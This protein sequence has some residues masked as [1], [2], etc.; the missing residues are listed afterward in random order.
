VSN[1]ELGFFEYP[2]DIARGAGMLT[3]AV[4][5]SIIAS[6][7]IAIDWL[8]YH[9]RR[10]CN[11]TQATEEEITYEISTYD[12]PELFVNDRIFMEDMPS[13]KKIYQGSWRAKYPMGVIGEA[14][15]TIA[16]AA[17]AGAVFVAATVVQTALCA[18]AISAIFV[19]GA[20]ALLIT[21][22][23]F[24]ARACQVGISQTF[25]DGF[26]GGFDKLSGMLG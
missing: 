20:C 5:T 17:V 7:G 22:A 12:I 9:L 21:G 10:C 6:P 4:I 14:A 2:Y 8:W 18:T 24:L 3:G 1:Y 26:K 23:C 16:N 13:S 11:N 25:K 19:L 15:G